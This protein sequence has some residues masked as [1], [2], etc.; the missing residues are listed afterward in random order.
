MVFLIIK[1]INVLLSYALPCKLD[2]AISY[3]SSY[4]F[5]HPHI[6]ITKSF[7]FFFF[8]IYTFHSFA[9]FIYSIQKTFNAFIINKKNLSWNTQVTTNLQSVGFRT[10]INFHAYSLFFSLALHHFLPQYTSFIANKIL[11]SV[12]QKKLPKSL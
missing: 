10:I 7:S 1:P 4:H 11:F 3:Y 6:L 12:I 8:C 2:P 5:I 9:A